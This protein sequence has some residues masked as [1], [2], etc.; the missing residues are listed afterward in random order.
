MRIACLGWGSLVWKQE[1]LPTVGGW[2]KDGPWLPLEFARTS[3]KGIGRLTLVITPGVRPS[4]SLWSLLN[5]SDMS[6]ARAQL[7]ARERCAASDIGE[8]PSASARG[9]LGY[10]EIDAW[11]SRLGLDGVVWTALPPMFGG[12]R[13]TG[14]ST[15]ADAIEYLRTRPE[16]VREKA[17][18]YVRRAP[19]Q[20]QTPFRD[21]FERELQWL[22]ID[23]H[24][25]PGPSSPGISGP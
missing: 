11:A 19:L 10:S 12:V 25:G 20:I 23:L 15:A 17:E 9:L 4:Q 3:D 21:A 24:R 18:E 2:N 14:P 7:K 13:G 6:T 22:P 1:D 8:W 5:A 16:P